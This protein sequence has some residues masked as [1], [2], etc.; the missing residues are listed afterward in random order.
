MKKPKQ[1]FLN[2]TGLFLA[3]Q[4]YKILSVAANINISIGI[5]ISSMYKYIWYY[6]NYS[7]FD[8][9]FDYLRGPENIFW[10]ERAIYSNNLIRK[11]DVVLDIGCGDG[12][13]SGK[14]YSSNAAFVDAID[15]DLKA[16]KHAKK[17]YHQKNINFFQKDIL[18]WTPKKIY[19]DIFMFAVIE[20]FSK[21][22][23]LKVLSKIG[24]SLVNGGVLFG[25][26]PVFKDSGSHNFEH[27]NEFDSVISLK[28]FLSQRFRKVKITTSNWPGR[29]ECYFECR[30][31]KRS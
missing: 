23:G 26:T 30:E 14:F 21:K 17:L 22:D 20:H 5:L 29:L 25:S 7:W 8:H 10:L 15:I 12:I 24:K 18:K 4:I 3:P 13:Y 2:K 19:N 27:K 6:T 1:S 9:R 28:R 31:P 16:I 11:G